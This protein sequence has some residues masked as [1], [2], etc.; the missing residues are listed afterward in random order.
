MK[1]GLYKYSDSQLNA[2][3][4]FTFEKVIEDLSQ[5]Q[6]CTLTNLREEDKALERTIRAANERKERTYEISD[7]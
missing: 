3:S 7:K 4:D 1:S 6:A 5:H 2:V